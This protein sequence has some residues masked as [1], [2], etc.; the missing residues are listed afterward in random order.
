MSR[1]RSLW[2]LACGL[3]TGPGL[4]VASIWPT[5]VLVVLLPTC[6]FLIGTATVHYNWVGSTQTHPRPSAW[7][8]QTSPATPPWE[9]SSRWGSSD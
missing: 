3:C 7:S 8:S 4:V 1:Y 2:L 6:G 5:T 9:V